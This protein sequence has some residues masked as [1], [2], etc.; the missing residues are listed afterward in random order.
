MFHDFI[1]IIDEILTKIEGSYILFERTKTIELIDIEGS[2][3]EVL[4]AF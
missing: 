3:R 1:S 4:E 2:R